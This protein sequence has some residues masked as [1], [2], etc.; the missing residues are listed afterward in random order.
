MLGIQNNVSAL[1][2]QHNLS[3]SQNNLNTSIERL[4]SGFKVNRGAD[5][6][7]A[8]VISEKQRA[9]I[10]GLK[11]AIDNTDKAVAVVQTAEGAL[12]E[13]NSLLVKARSLS[14]DSANTG[15]NDADALAANQAEIDNVLD[16]INR[17]AAN[18]QFG[19]SNLLDGSSGLEGTASDA[20][21]TF[22][23][24]TTD[25]SAGSYA[26]AVTTVG[27]RATTDATA[28]TAALAAAETLTLNGVSISLNAGLDQNAVIDRINE[29]SGQTGVVADANGAGG[30]T[31]LRTEAFGTAAT[32]DVIS[33]TAAGA[34]SS[35]FGTTLVQD[36]GVNIAGTIGGNAAT[37]SGNVLTGSA[38][39]SQ[40]IM[41]SIAE[42]AA[43]LTS[44]A[45]GA[46]GNVTIADNSLIFQIGANQNQTVSISIDSVESTGL[47]IG[48][49]GNQFTSL[50]DISVTSAAGA[51][52]SIGVIDAAIDEIST[53]RGTL[54]AFQG[55]TLEST[56]T[57][58]RS[59]LEN[60]VNAESVI[61][62][63]D[64]AD[65]I[66]KFTNSQVLVQA[67]ASVLSSANQSSQ[68]ILSLL[69]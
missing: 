52:D 10:A 14:I 26:V 40:G 23:K 25:T 9:Q 46:Q 1:N 16:T 33:D 69:G 43:D 18:T 54:G 8:L 65:E 61:R 58:M 44:T 62:D 60:T 45:T 37:G 48:V 66:S 32:I 12:T 11:T 63:T 28:Q 35:G 15:V 50:N 29:F 38:G 55:N 27:E 3:R 56:A 42:D 24:A 47:G 67:G 34:T 31:Q 57:N 17:I 22:L 53:L 13:I 36:S 68:L 5:G 30:A 59:T 20:D 39:A 21:V 64:F 19:D 49:A 41:V 4:S 6:P 51:Q 7:A 2:A